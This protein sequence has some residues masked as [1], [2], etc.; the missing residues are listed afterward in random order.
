V[1][2]NAFTPSWERYYTIRT[3][4]PACRGGK[5]RRGRSTLTF[6]TTSGNALRETAGD[7]PAATGDAGIMVEIANQSAE[8][9]FGET[10]PNGD[11]QM[12]EFAWIATPARP[13]D[14]SRRAASPT[15]RTTTATRT[16]R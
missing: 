16:K 1:P 5:P 11:F 9:L 8:Q 6:T 10:T 12:A 15:G 14:V 4:A 3:G 7:R 2:E 13:H